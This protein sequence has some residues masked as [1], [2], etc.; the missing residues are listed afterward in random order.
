MIRKLRRTIKRAIQIN[1][2]IPAVLLRHYS[3]KAAMQGVDG[4]YLILSFDCDTDKDIAVVS[5]V[6]NILS[7]MGVKAVYATPGQLIER[8][9]RVYRGLLE[10]DNEFI[11]HGY[12]EH[13]VFESGQYVS[14]LFYDRL[15]ETE[16]IED[17]RKGDE[18]LRDVLGIAPC[19]FRV[20]H[21]G[22]F[23]SRQH[24]AFLHRILKEMGYLYSSSTV[25]LYAFRY[26]PIHDVGG[27]YEIPVSGCYDMPT[28]ILDS[29]SFCF[30]QGRGMTK[31]DYVIQ[32]KKMVDFF[33]K[34]NLPGVLN[35]YA[36][37]SQVYD[38]DGFYEAVSYAVDKGVKNTT[39]FNLLT[40][41]INERKIQ[42]AFK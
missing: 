12:R 3:H 38:F 9:V 27:L 31:Q 34:R 36:D 6:A 8:G 39:Y 29:Y 23:Q 19:G 24:L 25:P 22:T 10:A 4:L 14:T 5:H 32:F 20:P 21:F 17:I 2:L 11:N 42:N 16:I 30:A 33:S 28:T 41:L 13:T 37:P 15:D 40:L 35:Y 7:N 26:G 1:P 18:V